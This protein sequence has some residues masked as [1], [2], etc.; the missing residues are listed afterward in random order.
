[1]SDRV[2]LILDLEQT[3]RNTIRQM[4]K[5]L[6]FILGDNLTGAEFGVL[7][8]LQ[9]KS[10]Q[11][12]TA[13]SQEFEVSVS[14]ITHVADQLERK[15]LACRKRSQLDK[16]VVELHITEEGKKLVE[17]L[18]QKKLKYFHEKFEG[19]TTEEIEKLLNLLKKLA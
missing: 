10:P 3:F 2:E 6:A 9:K 15:N 5:D 16:R 1:M 7:K 19:L 4:R 11:I 18:S 14:H 12:V 17:D 8:Q 13:L